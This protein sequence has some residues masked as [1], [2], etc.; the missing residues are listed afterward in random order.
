MPSIYED[1]DARSRRQRDHTRRKVVCAVCAE[2]FEVFRGAVQQVKYCG[3]E[4]RREANRRRQRKRAA[5]RPYDPQARRREYLRYREK[6]GALIVA[7]AVAWKRD[8]RE[9]HLAGRRA[10][11]TPE[12]RER[13]R[14]RSRG[15][16]RRTAAV[17]R[18]RAAHEVAGFFRLV[19]DRAGY[20]RASPEGERIS[21]AEEIVARYEWVEGAWTV[22]PP[23]LARPEQADL[24]ARLAR[25]ERREAASGRNI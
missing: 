8:N 18:G 19:R 10:L 15:L 17:K 1:K 13:E 14:L 5:A 3:P 22:L 7:R 21:P 20:W 24:A 25:A 23:A 4:C 2:V 12:R 6:H 16:A 11:M 9:K